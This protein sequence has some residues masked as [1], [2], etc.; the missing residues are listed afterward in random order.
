MKAILFA[1]LVTTVLSQNIEVHAFRYKNGHIKTGDNQNVTANGSLYYEK[2]GKDEVIEFVGL[3]P[4]TKTS[5]IVVGA[6]RAHG[7]EAD[8]DRTFECV[9]G[10][11]GYDDPG[12]LTGTITL[13][14]TWDAA[15]LVG[16]CATRNGKHWIF[17]ATGNKS[18]SLF[19]PP[20]E[21]GV[22]AKD[23]IGESIEKFRAPHV[24][25]HAIFDYAYLQVTCREM[26]NA[27]FPDAPGPEP[28]ALII[29]KDG[30]HC[31]ILDNEGSKFIHSSSKDKKVA[32]D[33]LAVIGTHFPQG[34]VF[35]R[36]PNEPLLSYMR[37]RLRS[38]KY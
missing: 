25:F 33:S 36:Y 17:G 35:K 38:A 10:A 23:L 18:N 1:L 6:Y 32:Y 27:R 12:R 22:R 28:G 11:W 5:F 20:A 16:D 9:G 29:G 2:R 21:A 7:D 26:L 3:E 24:I 37:Y 30:A 15:V 8:V 14:G 4:S 13:K 34:H 19:Y 31:A